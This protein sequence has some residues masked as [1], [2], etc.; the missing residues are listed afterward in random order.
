MLSLYSDLVRN[1]E[2]LT[3]AR[4]RQD[5]PPTPDP[6]WSRLLALPRRGMP[7]PFARKAAS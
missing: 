4:L 3:L 7:L 5:L 6:R 1:R 2:R